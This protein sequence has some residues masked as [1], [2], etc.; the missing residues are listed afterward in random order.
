MPQYRS[1]DP[2][3]GQ[4]GYLSTDPNAGQPAPSGA[5]IE[6]PSAMGFARNV[7]TSGM[8]MASGFGNAVMHPLQTIE[9]I[10]KLAKEPTQT[11]SM[12]VDAI[13]KR[14]G[15]YDAWLATAYNDPVGMASD[16][17]L[18]LGPAATAAKA[19]G[20]LKSATTIGQISEAL[21]PLALPA[22]VAGSGGQALYTAAVNP[23][24][25]INR[26][27]P[28]AMEEGMAR[29]VLP[30]EGGMARAE[31]A[32]EGSAANTR[33]LLQRAE[34]AGAA[35]VDVRAQ[36]IPALRDPAREAG[37]RYRLGGPDERIDVSNRARQ[38]AARN[39]T[40]V[41]LTTANELKQAAQA[42]ADT[43]FRAQERGAI[44]KD[45]DAMSDLKVAQAYRKAI[46]ANAERVGVS[47][48]GASNRQTQALIGLTQALEEA[49]HQPTRLTNLIGAATA[50]G[51]AITGGPI[52]AGTAYAAYRALTSKPVL[53]GAGIASKR[54]VAP[55]AT[56]AQILRALQFMR[57]LKGPAKDEQ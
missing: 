1:M 29:A 7:V 37:L 24:R 4:E 50:G 57:E 52:G 55:V 6:Q 19:G 8:N 18:V 10:A 23:S 53:A 43:A 33:G 27:F 21:N 54:V 31:S 38:L 39:P 35:P 46:E 42:K 28:G 40:G 26:A 56:R 5:P 15:S 34:T 32:L 36:V 3:A 11:G 41:P 17:S 14:Y 48:I 47:E 45:I 44:I 30:T 51:G 13:K 16:L 2:N 20:F 12:I 9:T 25:R 49:T 22:K